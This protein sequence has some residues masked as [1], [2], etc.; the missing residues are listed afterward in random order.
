MLDAI[1]VVY[2]KEEKKIE[3]QTLRCLLTIN[4][5]QMAEKNYILIFSI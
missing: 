3:F 1:V 4:R 2:N 5:I